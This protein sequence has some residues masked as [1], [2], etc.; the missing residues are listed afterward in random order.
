MTDEDD[1][2]PSGS[3]RPAGIGRGDAAASRREF[4]KRAG[5]GAAGAAI[6]AGAVG[7]AW[8]VSESG[9]QP[10][11][12]TD[13]TYGFSPLPPRHEPGFDHV[14]VIMY[15]NR[16][17]DHIFG[18]LY[19][20]HELRRGQRFAGLQ[21]GTY[22]NTAPDGTVVPAHV[23]EGPTDVVMAQP[24]P[25]PGEHYPHVNTQLFGTIDP[26]ANAEFW[27]NGFAPPWNAPKDTAHPTMSGFVADYVANFRAER[28]VDPTVEEYSRVMGGFSREMLP[29]FSTLARSFAVYD[30]WHCAVPSQTFCN[31]SFFHASTSHGFV[32]NDEGGPAKWLNAPAVPTIFNR[33]ED[34][35]KTWRVYYDAQQ[36]VS[37][38][39]FLHAPSI[40]KYWRTNF[41][42][43]EQFAEDCRTGRLPDY[44]FIEP[45]LIFDHNDMH[46]PG[47]LPAGERGFDAA[48]SDVRAAEALLADVYAA[49]RGGRSTSGSNALN[50]ALVVTF[51]EHGGIYDHVPP[52]A[53]SS[54]SGTR[55]PGEMGFTFD[56]L[57]GRVP[58]F[59]VS[60]YTAEGT[61]V[62]EPMHHASIIRTIVDLH[63]LEPLTH[64]DDDSRG[65]QNAVNLTVPRQPQLWPD[66]ARPYV[67]PNP[68]RG[69]TPPSE[70]VRR[71]PLT[72]PAKGLLG[73]LLARYEPDAP[74]PVSYGDAYDILDRHGRELFGVT[75]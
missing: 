30:H 46:P 26:P 1:H 57:G 49:V 60:A 66:V 3:P 59:V 70:E 35:G 44:A 51:D 19:A 43:M 41:R 63:G 34:A 12:T 24:D 6:G 38:T 56:R 22:A 53:S 45:R 27:Q 5:I 36:I 65:I 52:P 8:A 23:Y 62:N 2:D 47:S 71:H 17:F 72:A 16:S 61:I 9:A 55:E 7:A 64:R 54:P 40:E 31:R 15:E 21:H 37:M 13:D 58:T 18:R 75:D 25:D 42:G 11:N 68:E 29:V 32:T 50:T 10:T 28:G 73:L 20:D 33:L 48:M 69:R 74:E 39:G 14:V 4:L 67:P